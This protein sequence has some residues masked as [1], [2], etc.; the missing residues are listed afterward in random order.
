[1][2]TPAQPNGPKPRAGNWP[3]ALTAFVAQRRCTIF[4][5]GMQDC[6]QFARRAIE[7]M[8]GADP[9]PEV[10]AY[11]TAREAIR[12]LRDLGGI[13]ALPDRA[14]FG[15]VRLT[16]AGRGDIVSCQ[17]GHHLA[18]G[19]CLGRDAAFAG[20]AGLVYLPTLSCRKAWKV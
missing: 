10:Q 19:I 14:G 16:M 4:A 18:L 9:L 15:E 12:M 2:T 8:T 13:E 3:A 17:T 5:W 11:S 6:C 20:K 7:A 1:M